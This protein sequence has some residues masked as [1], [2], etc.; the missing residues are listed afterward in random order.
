MA[1]ELPPNTINLNGKMYVEVT[2]PS[3]D[4]F[5][6]LNGKYYQYEKEKKDTPSFALVFNK[7][8]YLKDSRNQDSTCISRTD[9]NHVYLDIFGLLREKFGEKGARKAM[10]AFQGVSYEAEDTGSYKFVFENRD[11]DSIKYELDNLIDATFTNQKQARGFSDITN[12]ILNRKFNSF[13]EN[14]FLLP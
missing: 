13:Y 1:E 8:V 5:V 3:V 4:D 10:S 7:D 2:E 9:K 12:R 6:E 11:I 14:F